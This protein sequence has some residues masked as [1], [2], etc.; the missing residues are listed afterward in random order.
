MTRTLAVALS[1]VLLPVAALLA[2]DT[3]VLKNGTM[4]E[5][6]VQSVDRQE[7]RITF[8][9]GQTNLQRS[10]VAAIHFDKNSEDVR[11]LMVPPTTPPS[12]QPGPQPPNAP[13]TPPTIPPLQPVAPPTVAPQL[14]DLGVWKQSGNLR[15]RITKARVGNVN[16]RDFT[17]RVVPSRETVLALEMEVNNTG[18]RALKFRVPP[19][20]QPFTLTDPM[21]RT[22]L[23]EFVSGE[24]VDAL[25][26]GNNVGSGETLRHL[27]VFVV[28]VHIPGD[29]GEYKVRLDT[30]VFGQRDPLEFKLLPGTIAR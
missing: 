9:G 25:R 5:G 6:D 11:R 27:E 8:F 26:S 20:G 17:G 16:V 13:G 12:P 23:Q 22:V 18:D 19:F 15:V 14:D 30:T 21:G 28:P 2:I 10:Q 4:L 1:A 29:A 7:V 24:I 3:V